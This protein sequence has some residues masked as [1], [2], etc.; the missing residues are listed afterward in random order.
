MTNDLPNVSLSYSA[1][2]TVFDMFRVY[3]RITVKFNLGCYQLRTETV[4][5]IGLQ[6]V[7]CALSV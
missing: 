3:H 4:S 2:I 7:L 5:R 6:Y 1:Y